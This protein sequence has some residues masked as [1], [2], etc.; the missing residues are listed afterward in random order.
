MPEFPR[1][2]SQGKLT[3]QKRRAFREDADIRNEA[4]G[5]ANLATEAVGKIQKA[6]M[7]WE[8]AMVV[9]Q[10]NAYEAKKR[11][12]MADIQARAQN[13]PDQNNAE[14]YK[15]EVEEWN[16]S[17]LDG[18]SSMAKR[19]VGASHIADTSI[20]NTKI[21]SIFRGKTMKNYQD[22]LVVAVEGYKDGAIN[23]ITA[24]EL[25]YQLTG[26]Y[27]AIEMNVQGG[28]ISR[29]EGKRMRAELDEDVRIGQIEQRV[30]GDPKGFKQDISAY[31]FKDAK[32]R[33]TYLDKANSIIKS[34]RK[35]VEWEEQQINTMGAYD[36]SNAMLDKSISHKMI[37]DMYE[38]GKI[39]SDTAAIFDE[40][41]VKG[42]YKIPS[43]TKK[44]KPDF[45]LRLLKE[46]GDDDAEALDI[47]KGAAKAYGAG[48]LGANQ[49]AYFVNEANKR[50]KRRKTGESWG[51]KAFKGA[52]GA[53]KSFAKSV[54]GKDKQA[55]A[56]MQRDMIDEIQGGA[57]PDVAAQRVI[58]KKQK[59]MNPNREKYEIN[60]IVTN[61]STGK[62]YKI[63]GYDTD[64]EPLV[65]EL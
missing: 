51:S 12:T 38:E 29:D 21:D 3:T 39:D 17:A 2:H 61:P 46:A 27:N 19:Q 16:K 42:V 57:D 56:E 28:I 13:D 18:M 43:D 34:N 32:E 1:Y 10:V 60:D 11:A 35:A 40:I 20:A 63:V 64:G 45:F 30:Y 6:A 59:A 15:K 65:D 14:V 53:V 5:Y 7:Q 58:E 49:Y 62:S 54:F 33:R 47:L 44:G 9:S 25:R 36:L 41:V 8:R 22:N 50:L 52:V 23:A 4:A 26:A 31:D 24:E 37:T 55:E 48:S